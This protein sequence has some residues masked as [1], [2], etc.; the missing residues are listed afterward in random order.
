[1]H[2][3]EQASEC[4]WKRLTPELV[5]R[6]AGHLHA[7]E[8]AAVLKLVDTETAAALGNYKTLTLGQERD[9]TAVPHRAEHPWPG[10]AFV[11]HWGRP[12]P[13]RSL[14]QSQQVRLL[15][16]AASSGHLPSLEAALLVGGPVSNAKLAQLVESAADGGSVACCEL[17]LRPLL[18]PA[19]PDRTTAV[20]STMTHTAGRT[21]AEASCS[22]DFSSMISDMSAIHNSCTTSPSATATSTCGS[23]TSSSR[24]RTWPPVVLPATF[25]HAARGGHVPVLPLLLGAT[26][27]PDLDRCLEAASACACAGGQIQTHAWLM[28]VSAHAC[29]VIAVMWCTRTSYSHST[30]V[31]AVA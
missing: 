14:S 22:N 9:D 25:H 8:V 20:N 15:C 4:H 2:S 18:R 24:L 31:I 3:C 12:E 16:L 13:W 5:R 28:Q 21:T 10:P 19:S 29:F 30:F 1:M 26:N 7:N 23:S 17:L 27:A 11:A 6:V